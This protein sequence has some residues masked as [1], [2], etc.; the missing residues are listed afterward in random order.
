[1][2]N[3]HVMETV[4]LELG[5]PRESNSTDNYICPIFLKRW[6]KHFKSIN[7]I[8]IKEVSF[9]FYLIRDFINEFRY[10]AYHDTGLHVITINFIAELQRFLANESR[11]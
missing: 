9:Y 5:L 8:R 7:H 3:I 11:Y 2:W 6:Y 1:M 10:F 4:E